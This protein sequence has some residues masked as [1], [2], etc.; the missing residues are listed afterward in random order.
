LISN[1]IKFSKDSG[2]ITIKCQHSIKEHGKFNVEISVIDQGI[3]ISE[4]D[5]KNIFKPF[6]KTKDSQSRVLNATSHGLGLSIC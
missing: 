2:V 5:Q 6:F 1:A 3:G 4:E